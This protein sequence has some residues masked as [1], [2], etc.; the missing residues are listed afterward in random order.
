M[1]MIVVSAHGAD[2]AFGGAERYVRD[3]ALGMEERGHVVEVLSAFPPRGA[4]GIETRVLHRTDWRD[5]PIRRIRNHLGDVVSAPWRSLGRHLDETRPD[6]IH[7]NNLPG[8]GTGIWE[9][10]RRRAIPVVHT[11]HDY[12]LLC[13]RTTLRRRDGAACEPSPLLC[14]ARTQRLARWSGGVSRL[15]AGSEH[16]L[17]RHRSLFAGTREQIIR[18]P[19]FPLEGGPGPRPDSLRTIGY[20]GALTEPKGVSLLLAG[21]EA[22]AA[23]GVE[24]RIAGEGPLQADV[25]RAPVRFEGRVQGASKL[26]LLKECDAGIVP[27]LWEEPSGP[28]YVVCEWMAAGRPVLLTRRGGLGEATALG[29]AV[30]FQ[31]SID[32]LLSA[33]DRLLDPDQW[34][35]V[36]E[37]VPVVVD[38]ADHRRWL[39]EHEGVYAELVPAAVR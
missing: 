36:V 1:R 27:S 15:I 8:I 29:G 14:G 12:Y 34:R 28:P 3:L 21:A 16:L 13:P 22:L 7:T 20:L 9:A 39:D 17:R 33:V 11:L 6:L 35:S 24:L 18:L 2:P 19:L 38:D 10:A 37:S 4:P 5:D 30:A 26:A 31:E 23:R 32:G 25:E